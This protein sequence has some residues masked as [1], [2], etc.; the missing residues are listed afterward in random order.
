[1]KTILRAFAILCVF[2]IISIA[3]FALGAVMMKRT[4]DQSVGSRDRAADLWGS[5]QNQSAPKVSWNIATETATEPSTDLSATSADPASSDVN[6]DLRLDQRLKGLVWLS[7]YDVGFD[8][9]YRFKNTHDTSSRG[10]VTFHLPDPSAIYDALAVEVDGE[11]IREISPRSGVLTIPVEA[12]PDE[13][14]EVRISYKSRGIGSWMYRPTTGQSL[15]D[16]H[17]RM[18]TNFDAID[19]PAQTLS[20][21]EKTEV[22]GGVAL[23]WNFDHIVSGYGMGMIMPTRIQPGELAQSLSFSAP[24]SLMFFFLVL[25]VLAKLRHLDIHPIN[26]FFLGAAFFAFHLL[27]AYSVDHLPIAIAFALSSV[28]SVAMVT[29]YLRLVVSPRFAFVEA[30]L[31]QLVYLIGFSLAHFL[32]GFTGLTLTV[33]SIATL[34][35]LMLLTGRVRWSAILDSRSD[36]VDPLQADGTAVAA[37]ALSSATTRSF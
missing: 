30:G 19:F 16:F 35:L 8:A 28:V 5:A 9:T 10:D 17:L 11:P 27:F 1:M 13:T 32:D 26:Y 7:L 23:A 33:L 4:H 12:G 21:S 6:V 24:I 31:A 18:T 20:P 37:T 36:A 14:R 2:G 25:S 15:R 34:F 22:A 3:W 29:S